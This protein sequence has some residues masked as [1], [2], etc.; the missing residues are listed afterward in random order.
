MTPRRL[1]YTTALEQWDV[2]GIVATLADDAVI[3]VAVH[4]GPMQGLQIA[5]FLFGVLSEELARPVATGEIIE[6]GQA[7]VLFETS[8][9]DRAAQGLN[10]IAFDDRGTIRELTV[11]FRPLES[12][13]RIAEAVG[14]RMAAQYGP[15][16]A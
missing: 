4:D 12:L 3:H 5:R 1:D 8:I 13:Q 11:F 14:A 15:P 10:V 9:G 7:V 16:P 2:D 6:A